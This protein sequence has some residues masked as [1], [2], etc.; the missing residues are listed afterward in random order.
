MEAFH[1]F[2]E[3]PKRYDLVFTDQAMPQMTGKQL[4]QELLKIRPDLP[5]I[6]STGHSSVISEEEALTLGIRKYFIKPVL[7]MTI[8][9]AIEE[10]LTQA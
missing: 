2:K 6:L 10:C 1:L 3:D 5:I 7:L 8:Q 4:S 9:Q